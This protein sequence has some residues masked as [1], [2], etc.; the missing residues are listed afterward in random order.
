MHLHTS[1]FSPFC[2]PDVTVLP[3]EVPILSGV[4]PDRTVSA[5]SPVSVGSSVSYASTESSGSYASVSEESSGSDVSVE[6]ESVSEVLVKSPSE[7][8]VSAESA[9]FWGLT[10]LVVVVSSLEPTVLVVSASSFELT[11]LVVSVSSFELTDLVVSVSSAELTELVVSVSSLELTG[12][13]VSATSLELTELVVSVSSAELTELVVSVSSTELTELVV[14]VSSAELTVL[15]TSASSNVSLLA[16]DGNILFSTGVSFVDSLSCEAVP[17]T[18]EGVSAVLVITSAGISFRRRFRHKIRYKKNSIHAYTMYH[19]PVCSVFQ[20]FL[21]V[22]RNQNLQYEKN[23][24][25]SGI[26]IINGY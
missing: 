25:R 1:F 8:S 17:W 10:E 20:F 13:S 24:E 18:A 22:Y 6:S 21:H 9:M 12:L 3:V 7:G 15:V 14:S 26:S 2:P 16:A 19:I 23:G 4:S 5:D 11:V